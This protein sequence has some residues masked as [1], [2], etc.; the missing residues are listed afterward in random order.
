[1]EREETRTHPPS[2]FEVPT[3]AW[4]RRASAASHIQCIPSRY[5]LTCPNELALVQRAV[6][7]DLTAPSLERPPSF[8]VASG[9][10]K[11]YV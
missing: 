9:V 4:N 2:V 1:M 11:A 8:S 6:Y 10:R 7:S 3:P 5:Q